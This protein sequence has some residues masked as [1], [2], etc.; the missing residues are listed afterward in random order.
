MDMWKEIEFSIKMRIVSLNV[1]F[2]S[3]IDDSNFS[4]NSKT[5]S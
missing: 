4:F 2:L 5:L 3:A 1:M